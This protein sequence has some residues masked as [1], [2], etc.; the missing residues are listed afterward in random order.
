MENYTGA[1]Y[2]ADES[3]TGWIYHNSG[4]VVQG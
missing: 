1:Q 2:K 4:L 3:A